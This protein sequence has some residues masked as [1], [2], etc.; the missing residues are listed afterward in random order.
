MTI[1]YDA[2]DGVIDTVLVNKPGKGYKIG[3]IVAVPGGD[4]TA[5]IAITCLESKMD[6]A[7]ALA[8]AGR[9]DKEVKVDDQGIYVPDPNGLDL[10]VTDVVVVDP[11]S[12]FLPNTV[13]NE[14]DID[15]SSPTFGQTIT[16]E[17]KP[18]PEETYDG[19]SSF[20]TSLGKVKVKNAGMGYS[21]DDTCTVVSESGTGGADGGTGGAE[22]KLD[23]QDGFI[24]NAE[25]VNSGSGFTSLP[26]LQINSDSGVGGRLLPVLK[27]TK[28]VDAKRKATETPSNINIVTVIDCVQH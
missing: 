25:V 12:S 8:G 26:E 24:V 2:I 20:V 14:L 11:G 4:G 19:L 28:V 21:P 18:N 17:V 9:C 16:T 6:D 1:N 13:Q 27:F 22:V 7:G 3:D 15:P 10:G 23:I 5:R